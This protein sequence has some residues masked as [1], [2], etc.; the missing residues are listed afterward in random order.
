MEAG[1]A[2][3]AFGDLPT[4]ADAAQKNKSLKIVRPKPVIFK[5]DSNYGVSPDIDNRSLQVINIAIQNAENDGS[6]QAALDKAGVVDPN[7]LGDLEMK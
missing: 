1:R 5:S 6:F 7:D 2:V 3:A 4:L